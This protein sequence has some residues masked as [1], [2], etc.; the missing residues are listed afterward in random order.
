MMVLL[1]LLEWV[2]IVAGCYAG[3]SFNI[4]RLAVYEGNDDG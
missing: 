3:I 4:A 1:G 2:L